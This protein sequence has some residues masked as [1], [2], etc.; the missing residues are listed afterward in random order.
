MHSDCPAVPFLY[1][2]RPLFI[3]RGVSGW[4][5][6]VAQLVPYLKKTLLRFGRLR[7]CSSVEMKRDIKEIF[8][9]CAPS[10][11]RGASKPNV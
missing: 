5:I 6:E 4:T 3:F 7:F 10:S 9:V 11:E 1:A 8:L 2:W